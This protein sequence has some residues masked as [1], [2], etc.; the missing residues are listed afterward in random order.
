MT[1][2]VDVIR[3]LIIGLGCWYAAL[4]LLGLLSSMRRSRHPVARRNWDA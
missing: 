1:A 2:V 4:L 3:H